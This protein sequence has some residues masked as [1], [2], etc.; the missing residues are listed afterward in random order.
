MVIIMRLLSSEE[1]KLVEQHAA[2]FGLSYQRM[3]ENAGT[4]CARNIRNEI[5]KGNLQKKR[6]AVVCGK[7]NNGGDG[8]V[9]ARKLF[10]SGYN[11]CVVLALGYPTSQ[12]AT[13]MYKLVLDQSI[14]TVWY[15]V[16][17]LK[18]LQTIKN[19]DVIVDA[20]FGFS[21]YGEFDQE[22]KELVREMSQSSA[23]KFAL[24][25]P[26]GVYCDSGHCDPDS[27]KADFTIAISALKPAHII[28]P[29][30]EH[31][32]DIIIANIGIPD[33][34]YSVVGDCLYTY[35]KAEVKQLF[36]EREVTAHKN[37]FGHVLCICGSRT[38]PGAPVLAASAALRSGAGLVTLAFPD[39]IYPV[40][41]S[42]L[43]EALL[44]PL[45]ENDN[46]TFSVL[47]LKKLL[48]ELDKFD[49]IVIGCGIG[50]NE[51]TR[52][53]LTAVIEN[54]DIPVVIDADALNVL[55]K[56]M[57]ILKKAKS[58]IVLTPHIGEMHRLTNLDKN[59]IVSEK[60]SIARQFSEH[61]G[62]YLVLKGANTVVSS[63]D[64]K[65]I[66]INNTGNTGLSKGGSGDVLAG[67]IGGFIAQGF[68]FIDALTCAVFVHGYTGDAVSDR[69]S[70]TGMLPSDVV[71][72]LAYSMGNFEN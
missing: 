23:M 40:V 72:E 67:L 1:M 39:S 52:A 29:A 28:H 19:A 54:A 49:S 10:E 9:V 60:I 59:I 34:S 16:D 70:K 58:K 55:S 57:S 71:N 47:A 18:T 5:E 62:V 22:M 66:Y 21:F 43:T 44:M 56:D 17:K 14:P 51:D 7:G 69:T 6:V 13:Y 61:Y 65:K 45:A 37:D 31:C 64:D 46:G 30:S 3:M 38:M 4:A 41:S 35:N 2:R 63:P 36:P 12:E 32:G 48:S 26:S 42:K 24:D 27:F 25:V 20:V 50:V 33:E 53:L 15:D 11:V 8:F 68:E